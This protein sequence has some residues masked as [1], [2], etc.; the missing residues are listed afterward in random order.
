MAPPLAWMIAT[1]TAIAYVLY[2]MIVI[3][4]DLA[5][6]ENFVIQTTGYSLSG[7]RRDC[8]ISLFPSFDHGYAHVERCSSCLPGDHFRTCLWIGAHHLAAG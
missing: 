2:T 6:K 8:G 3:P 7:V 5:K 4:L 1:I